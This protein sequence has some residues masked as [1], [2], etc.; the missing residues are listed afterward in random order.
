SVYAAQP[1]P[2]QSPYLFTGLGQEAGN[3][4]SSAAAVQPGS[5]VAGGSISPSWG[6]Y[7]TISPL[8]GK[9]WLFLAEGTYDHGAL[10]TISQATFT[11]FNNPTTFASSLVSSTV[12][13]E[14]ITPTLL[15]PEYLTHL[16]VAPP[17]RT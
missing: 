4:A 10:P 7:N 14:P 1:L 9:N 16:A 5:V 13:P 17:P 3:F 15:T 6:T 12:I 2:G 8:N 11:V